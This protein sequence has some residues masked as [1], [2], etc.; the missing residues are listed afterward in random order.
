MT[1]KNGDTARCAVLV[2]PY[3][4]GKTSLFEALLLATGALHKK[5][6]VKDGNTVGDSAEEARKRQAST[7]LSV[8]HGTYL[9][10]KWTF[11][12]TPG[13]LE[14]SQDMRNACM[15]AD[16]AIVVAEPEVAKVPALTHYLKFLDAHDIPHVIFVN[17]IEESNDR[18]RDIVHALQDVSDR[19]LALRQVPIRDGETITG[20]VD[21]VSERAYK[22]RN[23]KPSELIQLPDAV[24]DRE[25]EARNEMLETL[26]DFDDGLLEQ[27]LEDLQ[28]AAPDVYAQLTETLQHDLV[29][30]ILLGGAEKDHGIQRLLKTLRHEAPGVAQTAERLGIPVSGDAA[31]QIF[32]TVHASHV[33]KLSYARVWNGT[34]KDGEE[35][36]G[37]RVSGINHLLGAK[38]DKAAAV[39]AGDVAAFG[40]MD[41]VATGDLLTPGGTA[42]A[43]WPEPLVPVYGLA[44]TP[45][46]RGDEVK[47]SGALTKLSEEDPSFQVEHSA[48]LGELVIKGQG[49]T[50][51]KVM[52]ERLEGRYK[53]AVESHAPG[54]PYKESIRKGADQ[55]ARHK[56]QTG[57]HGQFGDVKIKIAPLGRGEG[58]AF[59]SSIVGGAV[60]KQ[61]IPAVEE[62]VKDYM[63][64]GPLGFEVV[65][66]A[67]ELYDGSFHA[68]DSSD[69]AFKTAARMAMNEGL[70]K[71]QPVLLEPIQRVVISVPNDSTARVQRIVTG[72]RGQILGFQAKENWN[73]WDEIEAYL[74]E[75]ETRDLIIEI[76]SQTGGIGFYNGEFDH[77]AELTGRIADQVVESRTAVAS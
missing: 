26:S 24:A 17:K 32:K 49:D 52:L 6:F 12:D 35:L 18:V 36:N 31:A 19:P 27:L 3:L 58:F 57:G 65:D 53:L 47:L 11:I 39:S 59:K 68:V 14:F 43:D 5:G 67:V 23:G 45:T 8:G 9:D 51:L 34:V 38:L 28:P 41:E 54:V 72:R 10:E 40:R 48:G 62:G 63:R 29:V 21:L 55:H 16:I 74:P 70:S 50:H 20:F 46:S 22:Y 44:I 75:S 4:S 33:G 71:C 64:R 15:V 30:P 73:G 37:Q 66:V 42:E 76:R 1:G 56:K 7:E 77:L 13:N 25:Q 60:P 61:Y 69:M 2:G